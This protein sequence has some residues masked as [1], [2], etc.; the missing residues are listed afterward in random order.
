VPVVDLRPVRA[1]RVVAAPAALDGAALPAGAV[2]LRLAPDEAL[3]LG[4]GPITV[5]DPHAL[6]AS[7]HGWS[8]AVL[9]WPEAQRH[10]LSHVEWP[11]PERGLA[12]GRVAGV[13]AK[14]WLEADRVLLVAATSH[15]DELTERLR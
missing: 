5:D 2:V 6:V 13:P 14:L 8:V 4:D 15:A 10:V 9:T 11:V 12:Q 7:D 3:V 1:T